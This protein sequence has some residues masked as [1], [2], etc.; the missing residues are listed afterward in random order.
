MSYSSNRAL[1]LSSLPEEGPSAEATE[2][3][4]DA[5]FQLVEQALRSVPLP[6]TAAVVVRL[7]SARESGA[8]VFIFGNGGSAATA[9]HWA[10]DFTMLTGGEGEA[11]LRVVCLNANVSLV[12]AIANDQGYEH[13]FSEQMRVLLR[14][15]DVVIGISGSGH[16]LNCVR[17]FETARAA[18]ASCIGILGFDGGV[19]LGQS[20]IAVHVPCHDY[21]AVEDVHMSIGHALARALRRT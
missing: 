20:D 14:K 12:S 4:I 9:M 16:S 18:G 13:V 8:T 5:H 3:I 15:G 2:G 7:R 19:M 6:S 1:R 21:L 17:A 11:A 10:N